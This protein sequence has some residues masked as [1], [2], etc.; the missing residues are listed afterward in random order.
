VRKSRAAVESRAIDC[1]ENRGM[2]Q[3]RHGQELGRTASR[4]NPHLKSL[5]QIAVENQVEAMRRGR[6]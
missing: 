5:G 6:M 4:T 3:H 2:P 1:E